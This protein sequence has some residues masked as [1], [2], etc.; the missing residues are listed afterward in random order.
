MKNEKGWKQESFES[1]KRRLHQQ[2]NRFLYGFLIFFL[3]GYLIFFT[4]PLWMPGSY[5]GVDVTPIGQTVTAGDRS[6]TVD[7]WRYSKGQKLM[8]IM[9]EVENNSID[10]IDHYDW[11]V[12]TKDRNL[13]VTVIAEDPGFIVLHVAEVP[14]DW[15]EAALTMNLPKGCHSK[16]FEPV[17]VYV[18]DKIV[19]RTDQIL[20][21]DLKE[22]K[23]EAY[24]SKL[25]AYAG[26]I[27]RLQRQVRQTENS[28][29]EADAKITEIQKK[30]EYQTDREMEE[31]N[32]LIEELEGKKENLSERK[33]A[34]EEEIEEL[35]EKIRLQ[36]QLLE[37][38]QHPGDTAK[39]QEG[40]EQ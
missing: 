31:S 17:Q 36:K 19:T 33:K 22:Y 13:P 11:Q 35:Q 34:Y 27:Q 40:H 14:K 21:K 2:S 24:Q 6:V 5:V 37:K 12:K 25:D 3:G 28:L 26:Q 7:S 1:R 23:A 8:E 39:D 30:M 16:E 4:S 9:I 10:G 20:R 29:Q 15:T 32:Q 18:N 38:L